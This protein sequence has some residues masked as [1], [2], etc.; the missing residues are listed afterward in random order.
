MTT[1]FWKCFGFLV[2]AGCGASGP[3][4]SRE[5][6]ATAVYDSSRTGSSQQGLASGAQ[7]T[8]N[9][10]KAGSA[11]VVGVQ[12]QI[13]LGSSTNITQKVEVE[14]R[15]CSNDGETFRDGKI[16]VSQLVQVGSST[17]Q[18]HQ[19]I[20]GAMTLSGAVSDKLDFALTQSVDVNSTSGAS[21]SVVLD[22]HIKS[23][24]EDFVFIKETLSITPG[25][26]QH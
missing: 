13:G 22:G 4:V 5:G 1:G 21:V 16:S 23:T 9:C 24:T 7:L 18:I 15:G 17:A 3:P 26:I 12:Q 6:A 10:T 11:T 2:L 25:D 19:Q 8:A 20:E 14:L